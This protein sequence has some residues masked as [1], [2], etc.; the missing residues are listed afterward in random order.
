M[1]GTG[2]GLVSYRFIHS[3]IIKVLNDIFII[4]NRNVMMCVCVVCLF[5][6]SLEIAISPNNHEVHIYKKS[7]NQWVKAHELKEHNGH[8]TGNP[9]PPFHQALGASPGLACESLKNWVVFPRVREP[10]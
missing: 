10:S 2:T 3:S 4:D 6:L 8:I 7:G 5:F 1:H 9:I